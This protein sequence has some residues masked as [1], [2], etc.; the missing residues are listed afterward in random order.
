MTKRNTKEWQEIIQQHI[1]SVLSVMDFCEKHNINK[2][3]FSDRRR[4]WLKQ[5]HK[6]VSPFIKVNKPH[7]NGTVMSL[8]MDNAKLSLP[9]H[10]EPDWLAHH[11]KRYQH[12]NVCRPFKYLSAY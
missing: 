10:T 4:Y 8:H 9:V 7:S 2:K 3:H 12:E 5:Q 1:A 6:T 11:S